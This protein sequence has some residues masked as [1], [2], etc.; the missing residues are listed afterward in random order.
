MRPAL[1]GIAGLVV[2]VAGVRGRLQAPLA[3]GAA[4]L[5]VDALAQL[6]PALA[7]AYDAVPRWTLI[8]AAGALLL[9]L[10]ATYERRIRDVRTLGRKFGGLR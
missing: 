7:A 9:A 4:A 8:A 5:A 3:I 10:G 2:L 1:V 6:L